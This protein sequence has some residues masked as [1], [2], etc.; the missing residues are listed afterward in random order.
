LTNLGRKKKKRKESSY[1]VELECAQG[2]HT[3]GVKQVSK[4]LALMVNILVPWFV[5]IPFADPQ[6]EELI[7]N[8]SLSSMY[9]FENKHRD[10]P[11]VFKYMMAFITKILYV[12][13]FFCSI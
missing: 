10:Y 3:L 6:N 12:I 5:A 11:L 1:A 13:S 2:G 8:S 9:S 7:L 4:Y